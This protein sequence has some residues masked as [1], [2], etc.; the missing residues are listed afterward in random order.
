MTTNNYHFKLYI[1]GQTHRSFS[2]VRN[3]HRI[4]DRWIP[5]QFQ[6]DIVDVLENPQDA[7]DN[8]ILATPTLVKSYPP[9]AQRIIGDLSDPQ[10]VATTLGLEES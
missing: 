10:R 5:E 6:I 8:Q 9:P 1:T 3:L 7:E 2:A 4:C